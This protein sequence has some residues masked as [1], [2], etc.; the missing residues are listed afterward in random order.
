MEAP[1]KKK[2]FITVKEAIIS[3]LV[4]L[5]TAVAFEKPFPIIGLHMIPMR[6]VSESEVQQFTEQIEPISAERIEKELKESGK[7]TLIFVYASW[8]P[9]CKKLMINIT[10]LKNEG[11]IN[12]INFLPISIDRQITPLSRYILQGGY[13]KLFTPYI[14]DGGAENYL[15]NIVVNMGGNYSGAIPYSIIF[16]KDGNA[17]D[18]FYGTMDQTALLAKLENAKNYSADK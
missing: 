17:I 6:N 9:F 5:F 16:D 4:I 1:E 13:E 10:S 15:R 7:P 8:C 3:V 12:E 11:K 2:P 18:N 14:M